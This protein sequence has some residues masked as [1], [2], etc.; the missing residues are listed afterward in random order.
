M[1]VDFSVL[2]HALMC[3]WFLLHK[4]TSALVSRQATCVTQVASWITLLELSTRPLAC[5]SVPTPQRY[6]VMFNMACGTSYFMSYYAYYAIFMP[7]EW[8]CG[9]SNFMPH[10]PY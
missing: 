5:T 2:T 10:C 9:T 4:L 8:A 3:C 6:H 1:T 7:Y